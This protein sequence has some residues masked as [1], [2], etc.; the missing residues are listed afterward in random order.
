VSTRFKTTFE[1][2]R[3]AFENI[4]PALFGGGKATLKL[5]DPNDLLNTGVEIMAQPPG[6]KLQL[7]SLLSGGERALTAIALLFAIL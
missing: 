2:I 3:D 7:L 5:T 1:A 6:K 4:F